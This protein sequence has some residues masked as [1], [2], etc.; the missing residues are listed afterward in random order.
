MI[1]TSKEYRIDRIGPSL[2]KSEVG[3]TRGSKGATFHEKT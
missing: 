3:A 2:I 1:F